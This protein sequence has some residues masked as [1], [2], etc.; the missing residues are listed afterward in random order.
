MARHWSS[1]S[2]GRNARRRRRRAWP[3]NRDRGPRYGR[4]NVVRVQPTRQRVRFID[5]KRRRIRPWLPLL[6]LFLFLL[7]LFLGILALLLFDDPGRPG[8][9]ERT[10][11]GN[12]PVG[13]DHPVGDNRVQEE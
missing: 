1:Y 4:P 5:G 2:V 13:D 7:L 3:W 10:N 6:F 11:G 8:S 12:H 9:A